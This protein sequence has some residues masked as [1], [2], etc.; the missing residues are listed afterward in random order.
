MTD[1]SLA[2]TSTRLAVVSRMIVEAQSLHDI[3]TAAAV[4]A[5]AV[6]SGS[7]AG[8]VLQHVVGQEAGIPE[9]VASVRSTDVPDYVFLEPARVC[10]EHDAVVVIDDTEAH[11]MRWPALAADLA[12]NGVLGIR[13]FPIRHRSAVV[14]SVVVGTS[15]PWKG[16]NVVE[17]RDTMG[18]QVIADLVGAA[19]LLG[20]DEPTRVR[21]SAAVRAR[22]ASGA[23]VEQAA[24][25]LAERHGLTIELATDV[26][27][28]SA[29]RAD[30]SVVEIASRV[31]SG[32]SLDVLAGDAVDD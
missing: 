18:V 5:A 26:L 25:I 1:S 24:G 29:F 3:C 8:I 32:T 12:Q 13:A 11:P 23:I 19:L 30:A 4:Q 20:A 14:G 15:Q 6:A 21:L 10:I 7:C 31:V 22:T 16:E 9:I 27:Y 2:P 17:D 28:S